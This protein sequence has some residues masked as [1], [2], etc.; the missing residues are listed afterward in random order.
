[1]YELVCCNIIVI[2]IKLSAFIGLNCNNLFIMC[3][4]KNMKLIIPL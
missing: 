4:I 3:G 1:M 2:L